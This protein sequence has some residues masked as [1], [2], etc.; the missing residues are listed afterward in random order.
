MYR[1][2]VSR[3]QTNHL[4]SLRFSVFYKIPLVFSSLV[5]LFPSPYFHSTHSLTYN[6]IPITHHLQIL[7]SLCFHHHLLSVHTSHPSLHHCVTRLHYH[8]VTG[9]VCQISIS[10]NLATSV[11]I[12]FVSLSKLITTPLLPAPLSHPITHFCCQSPV[13][14]FHNTL[15]KIRQVTDS[16]PQAIG[17]QWQAIGPAFYGKRKLLR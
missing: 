10:F 2:R 12:F 9:S 15:S 6:C 3:A 5:F 1:R 13:L 7:H 11:N 8:H 16:R 14:W 17:M 4:S